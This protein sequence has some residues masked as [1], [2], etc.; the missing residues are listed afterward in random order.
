MIDIFKKK[1]N[2]GVEYMEGEPDEVKQ[3]IISKVEY[4]PDYG[5]Y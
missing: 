4:D 3:E 5:N 2:I 1:F